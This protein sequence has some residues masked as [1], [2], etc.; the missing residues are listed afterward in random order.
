[1]THAQ[2]S[3]PAHAPEPLYDIKVYGRQPAKMQVA[4]YKTLSQSPCMIK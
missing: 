4:S 3:L 1:M 2:M